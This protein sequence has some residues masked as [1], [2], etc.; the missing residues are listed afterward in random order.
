LINMVV[1]YGM[2][3][4]LIYRILKNI[5]VGEKK[6]ATWLIS[7]FFVLWIGVTISQTDEKMD[8]PVDE[9]DGKVIYGEKRKKEGSN[10]LI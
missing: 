9:F 7:F 3:K 5:L 4:W 6:N 2:R 10:Q 8:I 1:V